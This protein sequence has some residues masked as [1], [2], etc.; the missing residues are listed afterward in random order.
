VL[1]ALVLAGILA[2]PLGTA[3]LLIGSDHPSR[4]TGAWPATRRLVLAI[5]GTALVAAV[6]R[7]MGVTERNDIAGAARISWDTGR[8]RTPGGPDWRLARGG[9]H[10]GFPVPALTG[11]SR[12]T[13]RRSARYGPHGNGSRAS[14]QPGVGR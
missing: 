3:A 8:A 1:A 6:M 7:L 9:R 13:R 14:W 12:R 11:P 2:A 5:T 10:V 4:T